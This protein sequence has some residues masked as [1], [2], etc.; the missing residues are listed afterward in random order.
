MTLMFAP[1]FSCSWCSFRVLKVLF[2]DCFHTT[3]TDVQ[4]SRHFA[5]SY[6]PVLP[7]EC[8]D[9]V[10]V[11][12]RYGIPRPAHIKLILH[13]FPSLFKRTAPLIDTNIWQC[14][15]T[16][17]PLQSYTDFRWF[18][19]FFHQ[20]FDYNA[21]FHANVYLRF[22]HLP[23]NWQNYRVANTRSV[24]DLGTVLPPSTYYYLQRNSLHFWTMNKL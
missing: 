21:L 16:I 19:T 13:C 6:S 11:L 22:A 7:N 3:I 9:A 5:E 12:T 2:D 8:I 20:E 17:L 1:F 14:L 18:T 4:Y 23:H 10:T 24:N 15:L